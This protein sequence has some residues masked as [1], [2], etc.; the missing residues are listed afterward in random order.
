MSSND[1]IFALATPPG[2][3]GVAIIRISGQG[4]LSTL[5][6]LSGKQEWLP[7]QLTFTVIRHASSVIDRA[8]AVYFQAPKSFTGEDVA[9]LHVHG[10]LSII[11]ELL[12]VLHSFSGLRMAEPG[13]FTKRA[14]L[15]GKMDL[16][17]AE[18]LGDLIEAETP[19]QRSQ[20]L[21]QMG[22]SL[23]ILYEQLRKQIVEALAHLE[24]YIDFPDEEI[25]EAVL[26]GLANEVRGVMATIEAALADHSRGERLREGINIIILGAPNAG[27]SSLINHLSGRD[28]AIVSA[29][30]GTT[31]DMIEVHLN[32]AGYSAILVDTAGIRDTCDEIEGEGVKRAL[33]RAENADIKLVLLDGGAGD[34]DSE[35]LIDDNTIVIATKS[36]LSSSPTSH[37]QKSISISTHTGQGIPEL[38]AAI[39]TKVISFFMSNES[40]MITRPRHRMALT[41]AHSHL[42]ASLTPLPLELQCEELRLAAGAIGQITGK[43]AVDDVLDVVFSQFCIGK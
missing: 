9:E 26:Q 35:K 27:K 31:R 40:V 29:T 5:Q 3:S 10:G 11:R 16:L 19:A 39:E 30:A 42:N 22:G 32:I 34:A 7:N 25:P 6:Q 17:E 4:A 38:L 41:K 8:M 33:A 28:V 24:A 21:R 1:T 13:E 15:N 18:G 2:K 36:D 43:I 20:A 12:A 23:S 37:H 14:F